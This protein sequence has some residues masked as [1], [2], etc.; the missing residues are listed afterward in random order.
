MKDP[1]ILLRHVLDAI[2]R[3]EEYT[4]G[5]SQSDFERNFLIQDAVLRNII[6]IGE[7]AK[8]IPED[9]KHQS[10][11]I[12]WKKIVGMRN[13]VVHEYF[14]ID[15]DTVWNVVERDLPQ[16]KQAFAKLSNQQKN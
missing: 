8:N 7:A 5:V 10:P 14:I 6:L 13:K 3:I 2:V 12:E 16:L 1:V 15:V 4:N 11:E 9:F